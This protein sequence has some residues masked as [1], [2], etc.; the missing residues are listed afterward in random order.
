MKKD[1]ERICK[2]CE[3]WMID[4]RQYLISDNKFAC[5]CDSPCL[6]GK[7]PIE[8]LRSEWELFVR[9]TRQGEYRLI[10]GPE[11]GCTHFKARP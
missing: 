11:F 4:G 7:L 2:N 10:V 9:T 3:S 8:S 6:W 5:V 1:I